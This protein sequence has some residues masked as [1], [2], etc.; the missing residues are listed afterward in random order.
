VLGEHED[1]GLG[2]GPTHL[3]GDLQTLGLVG[4]RHADVDHQ[5]VRPQLLHRLEHP[6]TVGEGGH[7]L[8]ALVGQEAGQPVPDEGGVVDQDQPHGMVAV[9]VVPDRPD[10]MSRL[11]PVAATAHRR[12]RGAPR[13][14]C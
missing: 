13:R 4:G 9:S 6:V 3:E 1:G 7:H 5:H 10:E 8:M 12:W 2:V 11:L 14:V